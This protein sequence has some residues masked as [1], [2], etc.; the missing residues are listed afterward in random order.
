MT[1]V[2]SASLL[3]SC[4]NPVKTYVHKEL[5]LIVWQDQLFPESVDEECSRTVSALNAYSKDSTDVVS[6]IISKNRN[7]GRQLLWGEGRGFNDDEVVQCVAVINRLEPKVAKYQK[8]TKSVISKLRSS[9]DSASDESWTPGVAPTISYSDKEI[10]EMLLGSP[11]NIATPTTTLIDSVA[12][13][14][15]Q[16]CAYQTPIPKVTYFEYDKQSK[17]YSVRFDCAE[18]LFFRAY[19]WE[20][21]KYE[22]EFISQQEADSYYNSNNKNYGGKSVKLRKADWD[23]ILDDYEKYA[24][25]CISLCR[26]IN[27]GDTDVMDSYKELIYTLED[28]NEK[29]ENAK[30][31]MTAS[32]VKRYM[33]ITQRITSA[34]AR[35]N[36]D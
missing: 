22:Y 20:D 28:L 10:C 1:L 17:I 4:S 34:I 35:Q 29:L 24:K 19:K 2:A 12:T 36:Q 23:R 7:R 5:P 32:Q 21:G 15:V 14:I 6:A 33:E 30:S 25:Q 18:P 8:H 11:R 3:S 13:A 31:E 27:R 9:V 26:K 16:K